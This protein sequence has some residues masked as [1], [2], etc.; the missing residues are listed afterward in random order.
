M[1]KW[2]RMMNGI[3]GTSK[4]MKNKYSWLLGPFFWLRV[5]IRVKDKKV[6]S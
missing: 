1:E 3:Q 4:A 2:E 6:G 5:C